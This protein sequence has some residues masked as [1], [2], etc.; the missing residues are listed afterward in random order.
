MTAPLRH[1][2]AIG[3][4]FRTKYILVIT[5][6]WPQSLVRRGGGRL[7]VCL[8]L[9]LPVN[10]LRVT[11]RQSERT[12]QSGGRTETGIGTPPTASCS[13]CHGVP[14]LGLVSR[15]EPVFK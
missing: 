13:Q 6:V 8:L 9:N 11:A 2:K 4:M 12:S 14:G 3:I 10:P 5:V 7:Q 15:A 1:Y